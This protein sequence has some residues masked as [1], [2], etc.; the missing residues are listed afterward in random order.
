MET[1]RA[2][3]HETHKTIL[4]FLAAPGL[5]CST[6]DLQFSLQHAGSFLVGHVGSNQ[7]WD[8]GPLHWEHGVLATGPPGKSQQNHSKCQEAKIHNIVKVNIEE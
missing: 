3:S 6:Q 5:S 2:I 1:H 7:G 8:L 4:F